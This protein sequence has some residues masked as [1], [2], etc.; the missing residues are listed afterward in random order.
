MKGS[1]KIISLMA[2]I[3]LLV[4]VIWLPLSFAATAPSLAFLEEMGSLTY[5]MAIAVDSGSGA[6]YVTE[7]RSNNNGPQD[8]IVKFDTYGNLVKEYL[9]LELGG[10]IAVSNDGT[11]I[12]ASLGRDNNTPSGVDGVVILSA[13][14][15]S[16]QG[17]VGTQNRAD[18]RGEFGKVV[19]LTFDSLGWLYVA[20]NGVGGVKVYDATGAYVGQIAAPCSGG[21]CAQG[22]VFTIGAMTLDETNHEIYLSEG[23]PLGYGGGQNVQVFSSVAP[24]SFQRVLLQA[25]MGGQIVSGTD[26]ESYGAL[27]VDNQ[28]RLYVLDTLNNYLRASDTLVAGAASA[29]AGYD[30]KQDQVTSRG[31]DVVY[32][33]VNG[34]LL[35]AGDG[36]VTVLGVDGGSTPVS[37]NNAPPVPGQVS[38]VGDTV[39]ATASPVLT[40]N[41]VV[42]PDGDSLTYQV[43]YALEG[44][45]VQAAPAYDV[46]AGTSSYACSGL[47]EDAHYFWQVRADDGQG[48]LSGWSA[49]AGFYVNAQNAAPTVPLPVGPLAGE[50]LGESDTLSWQAATDPDPADVVRYQVEISTAAD[51]SVNLLT[52]E[53]DATVMSLSQLP[54]VNELVPGTGYYWRVKSVDAQGLSSA[55]STSGSFTFYATEFRV[56]ANMPGA[57]VYVGG[58]LAYPGQFIGVTPLMVRD[59]APGLYT[60]VVERAGFEPLVEQAEIFAS[61]VNEFYA[62]LQPAIEP[63]NIFYYP[64]GVKTV[65]TLANGRVRRSNAVLKSGYASPSVADLDGDGMLDMVAGQAGGNGTVLFSAARVVKKGRLEMQAEV[66]VASALTVGAVPF[67]VDWNNDNH[68]DIIAGF[69][70]G[71]VVLIQNSAQDS[72]YVFSGP[73]VPLLADGNALNVGAAAFPWVVDVDEDG[74]KDLVV[75]TVGQVLYF[76]NVGTDA[77]P[78]LN[79]AGQLVSGSGEMVPCFNDWDADGVSELLVANNGKIQVYNQVTPGQYAAA[80]PL[81]LVDR[82]GRPINLGKRPYLAAWDADA[83]DGK[84]LVIGRASGRID[85]FVSRGTA[86]VAAFK[87]ALL[88]KGAQVQQLTDAENPAASSLALAVNN[89]LQTGSDADGYAAAKLNLEDLLLNLDPAGQAYAAANELKQILQ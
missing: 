1:L 65:R 21:T 86:H 61:Q 38:P 46:P 74:N 55:A 30:V 11:L 80:G 15:G 73:Q 22:Q 58:T 56:A 17:Y 81:S 50:M 89:A 27:L 10:P 28:S 39:V 2:V 20:D 63:A 29:W 62:S 57:R 70:D 82:R 36:G 8:K 12:Y 42:D 43:R 44:Q 48:G 52:A 85:Y 32:D 68:L 60:V 23:S 75:G 40:F 25:Q 18:G 37:Q 3:S 9:S 77:A 69:P 83:K 24:Y 53:V 64:N 35:I 87:D 19:D 4:G 67:I 88:D 66:P 84:D 49:Q 47:T 34:R 51:F 76:R 79:A 59:L 7:G 14:D 45:D 6:F 72:G 41:T 71:Q 5:S 54:G 33:A 78:V 31:Y 13:A 26:F 16:V